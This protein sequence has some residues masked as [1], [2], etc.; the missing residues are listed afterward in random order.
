MPECLEQWSLLHNFVGICNELIPNNLMQSRSFNILFCAG[1]KKLF[2]LRFLTLGSKRPFCNVTSYLFFSF[3][4]WKQACL[5][6]TRIPTCNMQCHVVKLFRRILFL[7]IP[8]KNKD[9]TSM[10]TKF[11][12]NNFIKWR[13]F[14]V[15]FEHWV[16]SFLEIGNGHF[17]DAYLSLYHSAS[18]RV[19]YNL[20]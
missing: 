5:I 12:K 2:L 10:Y 3:Y 13:N 9:S 15:N 17:L 6:S 16:L 11:R 18:C 20:I 7:S 4:L 19:R 1:K 14:I 8:K